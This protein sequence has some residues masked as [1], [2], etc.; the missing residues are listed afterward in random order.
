MIGFSVGFSVLLILFAISAYFDKDITKK[1]RSDA[2]Q[3]LGTSLVVFW[4]FLGIGTGLV[5][6][7]SPSNDTKPTDMQCTTDSDC[8]SKYGDYPPDGE[9]QPDDD[10]PDDDYDYSPDEPGN[11]NPGTHS[12]NGYYR[13][14]GTY[15][16]PHIRSNP[17]GD[18]SNNLRP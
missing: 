14:D 6:L 4:I 11:S 5:K 1:E 13:G 16:K 9:Y 7:S 3:G 2:I 15:V 12:V 8:A 10:R 17:D 18:R